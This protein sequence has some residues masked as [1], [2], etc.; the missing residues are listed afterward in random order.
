MS[1]VEIARVFGLADDSRIYRSIG[2]IEAGEIVA[3]VLCADL[4][5][6]S[7][8]MSVSRAADLW[9]QFLALFDGEGIKFVTNAG[10]QLDSWDPATQATF[11]MGVIVVGT[12]KAGCLWV[13]D[14]D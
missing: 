14:E 13:E 4:A 10:T 1:V 12:A 5:Y 8:M 6:G 3:H 9:K 7:V 2:I 11:D